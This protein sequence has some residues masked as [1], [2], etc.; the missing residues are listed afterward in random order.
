MSQDAFPH[1]CATCKRQWRCSDPECALDK[2]YPCPKHQSEHSADLADE[3]LPLPLGPESEALRL[4]LGSTNATA[5]NPELSAVL[6]GL[7]S[8]SQGVLGPRF[9]GL[10]LQGSL[11]VGDFD[12]DSDVDFVVAIADEVP[13]DKLEELQRMHARLYRLDSG[14]AQHL[15]GS[16]L[17]VSDLRRFDPQSTPHLFLDHG[18]RMLERSIH[19]HSV[20][21]RYVLREHGVA[22]AGPD[23][24]SL[25]EPIAPDLL[26]AEARAKLPEWFGPLL[27][28]PSPLDNRWMQAYSV[29]TVCRM[30]YTVRHC[31]VVSKR[32]AKDWAR[33]S[34]DPGWS[35]LIERAWHER[36]DSFLKARQHSD[37]AEAA[38]TVE[39]IRY[40]LAWAEC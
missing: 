33:Q 26:A 7:M 3:V 20:L 34:L 14:W 1:Y 6:I 38:A 28:D 12:E 37:P 22:L 10:Y 25:V 23:P 4:R 27:A 30:L 39:F 5:R 35:G 24:R 9:V 17:P 36:R 8:A 18:S 15:E 32:A 2:V 21:F 29:L 16:Y 40:G 19:D 11:A 13:D 31:V